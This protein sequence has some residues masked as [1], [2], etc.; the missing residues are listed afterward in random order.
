MPLPLLNFLSQAS[1]HFGFF[2]VG[3]EGLPSP[4][5]SGSRF[6]FLGMGFGRSGLRLGWSER[7]PCSGFGRGAKEV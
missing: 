1:F 7:G 3:D 2:P 6:G 4:E 5:V